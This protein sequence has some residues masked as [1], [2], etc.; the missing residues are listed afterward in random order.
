MRSLVLVVGLAACTVKQA[1]TT[2]TVAEVTTAAGLGGLLVS[3]IGAATTSHD[4]AFYDAGLVCVPISVLA[5]LVYVAAD[6]AIPPPRAEVRVS[7]RDKNRAT[8]WDLTK[9]AHRAA[10]AKDCTEVQAIEPRVRDLDE[11]FYTVVF[12]RDRK[13]RRCLGAAGDEA[14]PPSEARPAE[15]TPPVQP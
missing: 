15:S 7:M 2:R 3:A 5:A 14:L 9:Q 1:R 8:A 4:A 12:M 11:E 10:K 13:I 6:S